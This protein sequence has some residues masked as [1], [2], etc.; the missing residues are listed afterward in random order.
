MATRETRQLPAEERRALGVRIA[1]RRRAKR[2]SQ[3][4]VARRTGIR[5]MRLSKLENG[6]ASPSLSELLVLAEALDAGLEEL[7]RG[8]SPAGSRVERYLGPPLQELEDLGSPEECA[9]LGKLLRV[10]VAGFKATRPESPENH[11]GKHS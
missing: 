4:E 11:E 7:V 2:W 9:I 5:S 3:R 1:E 10:L 6:H 8:A